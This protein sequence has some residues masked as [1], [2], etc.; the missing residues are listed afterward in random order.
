MKF[1]RTY[2]RL[3]C[4]SLNRD[5][6]ENNKYLHKQ[7]KEEV[8]NNLNNTL[9]IG[10]G[11]GE[12]L[13]HR[14]IKNPHKN[15]MAVDVYENG[16]VKVLKAIAIDDKIENLNI[17]QMDARELINNIE[18]FNKTNNKILFQEIYILFPDPWHKKS[19]KKRLINKNLLISIK[20]I[21]VPN[22]KLFFATDHIDYFENVK[23]TLVE[24]GFIIEKITTNEYINDDF[25]LSNY[26]KKAVNNKHYLLAVNLI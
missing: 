19:E 3:R 10:F 23:N 7:F 16:I 21:L 24:L 13:L 5:I 9:E 20:N 11:N 6:M 1:I 26:E 4:R 25:V 8:F 22:G 18:E 12:V 2:G 17:F 15:H 14:S